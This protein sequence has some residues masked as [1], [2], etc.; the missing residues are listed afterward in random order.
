LVRSARRLA[1]CPGRGQLSAHLHPFVRWC[2]VCKLFDSLS[3]RVSDCCR[4]HLIRSLL[5][6]LHAS[7]QQHVLAT[8]PSTILE[9]VLF[10]VNSNTHESIQLL[11]C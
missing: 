8:V 5:H 9:S 2:V 6:C 1:F 7:I 11:V 4:E 3:K 10:L